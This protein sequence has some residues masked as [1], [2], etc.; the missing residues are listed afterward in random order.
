MKRLCIVFFLFFIL[1]SCT[2]SREREEEGDLNEFRSWIDTQTSRLE[3]RTEED[4]QKTKVDF[5]RRTDELD[6]KQ[7]R[8]TEQLKADYQRLK[9]DFKER[10]KER[11]KLSERRTQLAKWEQEL[12]GAYAEPSSV[13]LK[14]IRMAYATL[15]ENVR[16]RHENWDQ[17]DWDMANLVLKDLNKRKEAL[18][19]LPDEEEVQ[20]KALQMEISAMETGDETGQN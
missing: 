4:W 6:R 2:A 18:G 12:L 8:F 17:E 1:S 7:E 5:K 15:V 3:E 10:E 20:I 16:S 14:N 13:N 9:E 19:E 11:D